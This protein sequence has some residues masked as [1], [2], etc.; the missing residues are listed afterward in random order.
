MY[1]RRILTGV[2]LTVVVAVE[3]GAAP[4]PSPRRRS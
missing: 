3:F 2:A 4:A 1:L